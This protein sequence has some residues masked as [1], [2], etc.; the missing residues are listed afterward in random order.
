M[1][2]R[3]LSL[4]GIENAKRFAEIVSNNPANR[5]NITIDRTLDRVT[6]AKND[7]LNTLRSEPFNQSITEIR[8]P[9]DPVLD[10]NLSLHDDTLIRAYV[11]L[12]VSNG[13]F[14]VLQCK[15]CLPSLMWCLLGISLRN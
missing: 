9:S 11:L 8:Y 7:L 14:L 10:E 4:F 12:K 2:P 6:N 5:P 15:T 13:H 3:G 1:F